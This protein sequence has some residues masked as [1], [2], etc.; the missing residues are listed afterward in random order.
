[1]KRNGRPPRVDWDSPEVVERTRQ[2]IHAHKGVL[3][4]VAF[5]E[6]RAKGTS[7]WE[8]LR[9]HGLWDDVLRARR[10]RHRNPLIE[11]AKRQIMDEQLATIV[12]ACAGMSEDE[13]AQLIASSANADAFPD[14]GL[15]AAYI[16]SK[17]AAS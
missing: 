12:E 3:N 16:V 9:R 1:M 5:H 15:V 14:P 6:G 11:A 4:K 8:Y 13:I 10:N 7:F 2:L 17:A